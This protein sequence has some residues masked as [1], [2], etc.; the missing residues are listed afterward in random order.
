MKTPSF[1]DS[2][3]I[4]RTGSK[5]KDNSKFKATSQAGWTIHGHAHVNENGH[6]NGEWGPGCDPQEPEEMR[7]PFP[8]FL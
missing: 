4:H 7:L 1:S 2:G 6:K 5:P 8:P 3:A